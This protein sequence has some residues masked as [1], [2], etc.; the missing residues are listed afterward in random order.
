M[1]AKHDRT[2]IVTTPEAEMDPGASGDL[3]RSPENEEP[4]VAE[5]VDGPVTVNDLVDGAQRVI[6]SVTVGTRRVVDRG[7]Y[8]KLRITRKGKPVLPDIPLA[9]AAALEAASIAGAGLARTLAVNVGAQFLF[10]VEVVNEADRFLETGR[11]AFL[12]GDMGTARTALERAVT[13]DDTHAEAY[14]QLGILYRLQGE[15]DLAVRA[16]RKAAALDELGEHGKRAGAILDD[17]HG[18]SRE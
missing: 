15:L 6:D 2:D 5:R 11:E 8:R 9:A 3:G 17:L 14:L 1:D 10:D 4:I 13:V 12:D 7:R 18:P 16:L